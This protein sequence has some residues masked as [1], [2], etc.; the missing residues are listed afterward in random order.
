MRRIV[1]LLIVILTI[2]I[3][4][5]QRLLRGRVLRARRMSFS[6]SVENEVSGKTNVFDFSEL[7][8]AATQ[9]SG[10]GRTSISS[11]I[12]S[13]G[14]STQLQATNG[15]SQASSFE[16]QSMKKQESQEL[17]R[18]AQGNT[19]VNEKKSN[20]GHKVDA[21]NKSLFKGNGSSSGDVSIHGVQADVYGSKG[22]ALSNTFN[23]Q[24]IQN[25]SSQNFIQ[26]ESPRNNRNYA[27][28]PRPIPAPFQK[29]NPRQPNHF[30]P[31]PIGHKSYQRPKLINLKSNQN[32]N[33][34][35]ARHKCGT[36]TQN[37]GK[38]QHYFSGSSSQNR[39]NQRKEQG[40][41]NRT[42]QYASKP[43]K[44]KSFYTGETVTNTRNTIQKVSK[45]PP[46]ISRP[47]S[48]GSIKVGSYFE[49]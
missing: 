34:S 47:S 30:I 41:K 2:E 39:N 12:N 1:L 3:A 35:G 15:G 18:D 28:Q 9:A 16:Q 8:K 21:S 10:N 44:E 43:V 36:K 14:T 22:A 29:P 31:K 23:K 6:P 7:T 11:S 33:N 17:R 48:G 32:Q 49:E 20:E 13:Q 40:S 38:I 4:S 25:S 27:P 24:E 46:L 26:K 42:F 37:K 19:S 5:S 45:N